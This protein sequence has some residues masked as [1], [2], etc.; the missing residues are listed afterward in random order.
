MTIRPLVAALIRPWL[1][2]VRIIKASL[3]DRSSYSE[4]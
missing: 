4:Y 1:G 3:S 2:Y